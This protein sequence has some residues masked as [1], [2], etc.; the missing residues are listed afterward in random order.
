MNNLP[1]RDKII[2]F[3][4]LGGKAQ[5]FVAEKLKISQSHVSRLEKKINN[6]VQRIS[7]KQPL[8]NNGINDIHFQLLENEI[9]FIGF[10]IR[11]FPNCTKAVSNLL[12]ENTD[13]S[14]LPSIQ[15]KNE[16]FG[17]KMLVEDESFV[18]VAKLL[19]NL[20]NVSWQKE[21]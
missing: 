16:Y 1:I 19:E 21:V 15:N 7:A 4:R 9:F 14:Y 18:F 13:F 5:K 6:K 3:Y 2:F 11:K 17:V 12:N 10:S 8:I 20:Y